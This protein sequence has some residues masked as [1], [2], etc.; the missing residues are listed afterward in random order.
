MEFKNEHPPCLGGESGFSMHLAMT[1]W[2]SDAGRVLG[3]TMG[4]KDRALENAWAGLRRRGSQGRVGNSSDRIPLCGAS[5]GWEAGGCLVGPG[6]WP[7]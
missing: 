2:A 7:A 5:P 6:K 1:C 3:S 4:E